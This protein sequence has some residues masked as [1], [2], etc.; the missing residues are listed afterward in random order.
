MQMSVLF[1]LLPGC[2]GRQIWSSLVRNVKVLLI[3]FEGII[4]MIF[5][6]S[7]TDEKTR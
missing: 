6:I 1:P 7:I 4:V 3:T 2:K 5:D